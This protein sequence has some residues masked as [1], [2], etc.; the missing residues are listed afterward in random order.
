MV[1][2]YNTIH[3]HHSKKSTSSNDHI[4]I[5]IVKEHKFIY[6]YTFEGIDNNVF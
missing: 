1:V 2:P 5:R 6:I 3:P 4:F